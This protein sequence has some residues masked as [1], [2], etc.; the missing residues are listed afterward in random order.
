MRDLNGRYAR[1]FNHRRGR[2]GPLFAR[3][4]HR[5]TVEWDGHLLAAVRYIAMNPVEAG[6]CER[7][8]DWRWSSHQALAGLIRAPNFLRTDV[9]LGMLGSTDAYVRF[10]EGES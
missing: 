8:A 9:V 3:R 7:P 6:L 10:V 1:W 4:F 5:T 2:S